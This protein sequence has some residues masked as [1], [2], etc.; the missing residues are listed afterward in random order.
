MAWRQNN[1]AAAAPLPGDSYLGTR[2]FAYTIGAALAFHLLAFGIWTAV[3]RAMIMDIPVRVLNIKLGDGE[4]QAMA[5]GT[6]V[7]PS[8]S[9]NVRSVEATLSRS[10]EQA[11]P[12]AAPPPPSRG[13]EAQHA[14]D[15]AM[16]AAKPQPVLAPVAEPKEAQDIAL[17]PLEHAARQFV[18]ARAPDPTSLSALNPAA[19]QNGSVMG[20]SMASDAEVLKRYE[21]M[22]SAWI[23]RFKVYPDEARRQSM[24]GEGVVRIRIDRRG[25]IQYRILEKRTGYQQLD[26]AILEMVQKANPVPPVP[27]NYPRS[28]EILEFLVPV[29]FRLQ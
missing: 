8:A 15:R 26:R 20:N 22:I 19:G 28:G 25:N 11:V 29:S 5:A 1:P 18:R 6:L 16:N 21:Q 27:E 14:F 17:T 12:K 23:Q 4:E 3:P 7:Q 13:N 24:Q 2:Q 10:F 9:G